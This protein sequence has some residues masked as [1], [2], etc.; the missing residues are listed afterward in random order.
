MAHRLFKLSTLVTVALLLVGVLAACQREYPAREGEPTA[1]GVQDTGVG[2][3]AGTNTSV[4]GATVISA[5]TTAPQ[6]GTPAVGAA[7]T[8][9]VPIATSAAPAAGPTP[10]PPGEGYVVYT[11]KPGDT[12]SGIAAEYGTTTEAIAQANGITDPS[13]IAAGQQLKIPT[14]SQS[15][16]PAAT[17]QP[18]SGSCGTLVNSGGC[19]YKYTLQAGEWVYK[20][21]RRCGWSAPAIMSANG[22]TA[23]EA[24]VLQPGT[25]LCIP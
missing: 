6:A 1:T 8:P 21:A 18:A 4:P 7:L 14:T 23:D 11:V 24:R 16:A 20:V 13:T 25:V 22:L 10:I 17:S 5:V 12:L 15:T 3:P 9:T 2:V 19:R